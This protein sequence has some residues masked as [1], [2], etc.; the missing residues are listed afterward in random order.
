[1]ADVRVLAISGSARRGSFNRQLASVAAALAYSGIGV[2]EHGCMVGDIKHMITVE[3]L[4]I[5]ETKQHA[6]CSNRRR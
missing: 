2:L 3:F 6:Q 5:T 1:M 4:N